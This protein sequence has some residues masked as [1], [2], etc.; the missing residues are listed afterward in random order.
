MLLYFPL[1]PKPYADEKALRLMMTWI[2]SYSTSLFKNT[3]T[4]G[5]MDLIY[6]VLPFVIGVSLLQASEGKALLENEG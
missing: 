4:S 2:V 5:K 1:D 6:D 3:S